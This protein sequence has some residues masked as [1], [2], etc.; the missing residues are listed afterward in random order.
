[1]RRFINKICYRL[2]LIFI[3]NNLKRHIISNNNKSFDKQNCLSNDLSKDTG[4]LSNNL[5]IDSSAIKLSEDDNE[6]KDT[7]SQIRKSSYKTTSN[8]GLII[9]ISL[10]GRA[11]IQNGT[12]CQ[13]YHHVECLADG[14][15]LSIVS[16]GAG[17]AKEAARGSKANCEISA[18]LIS[19]L[20]H[21]KQWIENEY[22][23][24]EEEWHIEISNILS[25]TKQIIKQQANNQNIDS[26]AFNATILI[27]LVTPLG[28]LTAHIGDGRM[29]YKS[30][31]GA[32][33]SLMIPHKGEE[34][35]QTVFLP[36]D[37]D[38]TSVPAFQMSGVYIPETR[39]VKEVPSSY[40]LI[41]DGCEQSMW[42]C[43]MYNEKLKKYEDKNRP[44][45][46]FLDPLI[47]DILAQTNDEQQRINRLMYIIDQG[48]NSCLREQ[49]D[50]TIVLGIL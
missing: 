2:R 50:R 47:T 29:G 39:V 33:Y 34:A 19:K 18:K 11:H 14:W 37:W 4:S 27:L 17:S 28:M 43:H 10:Q 7:K 25:L 15:I 1:M 48:T 9:G 16:D 22:L 49:D 3:R 36:N 41:S 40:I 24:T 23:P 5:Q 45:E 38:I 12:P 21:D 31:N 44:Y 6:I 30:Q 26:R 42:M 35:S 13:D 46:R 32:W 20:L 8:K